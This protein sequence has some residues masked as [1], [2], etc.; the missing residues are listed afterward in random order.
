MLS[1][2]KGQGLEI[3]RCRKER[4][5]FSEVRYRE[6]VPGFG[7]RMGRRRDASARLAIGPSMAEP[8]T[9]AAARP[10][11]TL[12]GVGSDFA[13]MRPAAVFEG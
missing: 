12:R 8:A 2:S 6:E 13:K 11:A 1:R 9:T 3:V 10:A 7:G 4:G 5:G